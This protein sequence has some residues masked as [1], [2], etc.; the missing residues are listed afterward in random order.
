MCNAKIYYFIW[1]Y[2]CCRT[3]L[4]ATTTA[5]PGFYDILLN[6]N[7]DCVATTC[8]H[9]T[10]LQSHKKIFHSCF[11]PARL[12]SPNNFFLF[13]FP[14]VSQLN[15]FHIISHNQKLWA[16][17]TSINLAG[18]FVW[19]G[20]EWNEDGGPIIF[21]LNAICWTFYQSNW[22]SLGAMEGGE[23]LLACWGWRGNGPA[24]CLFPDD[25]P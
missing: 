2:V 15:R 24:L 5:W 23:L 1:K 14:L 19:R 18:W 9:F 3:L 17:V 13:P 20:M 10:C 6:A 16:N 7:C 22:W 21:S 4:Y 11:H 12:V 25:R 8:I